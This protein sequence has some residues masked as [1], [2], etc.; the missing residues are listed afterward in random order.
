MRPGV[1]RTL[2]KMIKICT[3]LVMVGRYLYKG[4]ILTYLRILIYYLLLTEY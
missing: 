4:H 3:G 1:G 2:N